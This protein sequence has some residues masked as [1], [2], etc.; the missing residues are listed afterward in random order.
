MCQF[1]LMKVSW[2]VSKF[3]KN[4]INRPRTDLSRQRKRETFTDTNIQLNDLWHQKDQRQ[5]CWIEDCQFQVNQC[6]NYELW[7]DRQKQVYI[8]EKRFFYFYILLR[9]SDSCRERTR[10]WRES[11]AKIFYWNVY[12]N[13]SVIMVEL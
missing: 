5:N 7:K 9:M 4:T 8:V 10:L 11:A 12:S 6:Q 2:S 3:N 1:W 13:F